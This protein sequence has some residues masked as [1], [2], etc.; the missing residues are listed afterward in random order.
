MR[1][2]GNYRIT[3]FQII[4]LGFALMI[5]IGTVL[6]MLPVSSRQ[7]TGTGSVRWANFSPLSGFNTSDSLYATYNKTAPTASDALVRFD[8]TLM[9]KATIPAR[10]AA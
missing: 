6:L 5:L 10:S 7:Q 9:I 3:T 8:R 2:W 4:A 1:I